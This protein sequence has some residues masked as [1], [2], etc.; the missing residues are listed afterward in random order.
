MLNQ[1]IYSGLSSIIP[2]W[3]MQLINIFGLGNE[4]L[5]L[6]N[7]IFGEMLK[8]MIELFNNEYLIFTFVLLLT[9]AFLIKFD[10]MPHIKLFNKNIVVLKAIEYDMKNSIQKIDYC[11]K[12]LSLNQYLLN[13][14]KV[15][16][17][18]YCDN[19]KITINDVTNFL[20]ANNVYLN[21]NRRI[22]NNNASTVFYTLW[23][24]REDVDA[25]LQ[26]IIDD[27]KNCDDNEIVLYGDEAN[28][29]MDYPEPIHAINLYVSKNFDFP[30]LKC[31]K[32]NTQDNIINK[33]N[34]GT[35]DKTKTDANIEN[36][37]NKLLYAYTLN[38]ITN[39]DLGG[40]FLSVNRNAQQRLTYHL[41][42]STIKCKKWLEDLMNE[43]DINKIERFKNRVILFGAEDIIHNGEYKNYCYNLEMWA[44]NWLL[45]EKMNCQNFQCVN[46]KSN[47]ILYKY[48]LEPMTTYRIDD[49]LYL[50]VDKIAISRFG[51]KDILEKYGTPVYCDVIYTLQS[52]DKNLK[53]EL[54]KIVDQF[55]EHRNNSI[56]NKKIYHFTYEGYSN[57]RLNFNARL[58]SE[59]NTENELFETFDN[60]YNEHVDVLKNDIDRLKNLDYYKKHGL[61]RKKGYLFH[62]IPGCG[63]TS[64]VVAMALY[65]SRHIVEI[66]F[67]LITTHV[68]FDKIMNIQSINN[69]EINNNNIILLF[70]EIDVGMDKINS[71]EHSSTS[72]DSIVMEEIDNKKLQEN[73]KKINI[74][75]LLSKLDGIGNY[76]G[77]IIVGT[78]NNIHKIN[79][80]LYREM[81]LTPYKFD[82]L[83]KKDCIDLIHSYFD[84]NYDSVLNDLIADRSIEP[85]KLIH[86]CQQYE[87]MKVEDFIKLIVEKINEQ[88]TTGGFI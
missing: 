17:I 33:T 18:T 16:N 11:H 42:S 25:F 40:I 3:S 84:S 15:K 54:S 82:K 36:N 71:S 87:G 29:K 73:S 21:I 49:D 12:I 62:G 72:C 52:N 4:Y 7:L 79:P 83:R 47:A 80:S 88:D 70:D 67:A 1:A 31:M 81:R 48:V 34:G 69:I 14:K 41:T 10:Y 43:Y 61:K 57:D 23:S 32:I 58:L 19:L 38:D 46:S 55:N 74:G 30:K 85:A 39:F 8:C 63:K 13:V 37:K 9:I 75:T 77:L 2:S 28:G 59:S 24:Y 35:D 20:L 65:D 44:I 27:Y 45:I 6:F 53:V 78:T 68:E 56:G 64:T 22:E 86:L 51:K 60:I 50:S 66:P 76:N 5:L 26:K